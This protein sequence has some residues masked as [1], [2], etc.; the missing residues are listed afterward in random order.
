MGRSIEFRS[1]IYEL[2]R[3][4]S[5]PKVERRPVVPLNLAVRRRRKR[6]A[7]EDLRPRET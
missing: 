2:C 6:A 4:T 5:R 1:Y 7:R 3:R